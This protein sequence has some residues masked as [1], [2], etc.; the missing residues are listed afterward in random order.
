MLFSTAERVPGG[1][2]AT[3]GA[4][5][6]LLVA[7]LADALLRHRLGWLMVGCGVV[8]ALGVGLLVL[9]GDAQ[10]DPSAS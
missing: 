4:L 3:L 1:V 10:L 2:A 6:P 5:Q 8:G 7:L 9:R